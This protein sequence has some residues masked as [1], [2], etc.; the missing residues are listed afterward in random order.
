MTEFTMTV[1]TIFVGQPDSTDEDFGRHIDAVMVEFENVADYDMT[2]GAILT[3]RTADFSAIVPAEAK[4][5][6][7][8]RFLTDLRCALHAAG[9]HTPNWPTGRKAVEP[10]FE[11]SEQHVSE[12]QPA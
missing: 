12:L 3:E 1:Q 9:T 11:V 2:I 7:K 4:D 10:L 6:A 8:L 5:E